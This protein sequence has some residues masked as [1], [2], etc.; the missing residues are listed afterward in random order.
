M[1]KKILYSRVLLIVITLIS[2]FTAYSQLP[3][4]NFSITA[5][6]QTCLNNGALGFTVSGTQPGASMNYA[7][8]LLPNTTTPVITTTSATV[9]GL[10]A[11]NYSVTATQSLNGQTSTNTQT[12]TINNLIVPLTY[13]LGFTKVKCGNDGT[14]TVTATSGYPATYEILTGP[15]TKAPQASN[16]FTGLPAGLYGVRVYDTCGEAVVISITVTQAVPGITIQPTLLEEL[17][18]AC[19]LITVTNPLIS[20]PNT[21]MF[22]PLTIQYTVFPPG[23]GAPI[24]LTATGMTEAVYNIP[25][26][27]NQ[28]YSYTI[29]ITDACGNI[30]T[31]TNNI[32][33]AA[34]NAIVIPQ[35][36]GC[37][38]NYF[39]ME[40]GFFVPPYTLN[41]T[42]FPVGFTPSALN[43][44]HPTFTED[45]I[46][47][48]GP[49]VGTYAPDG[50]YTVQVTD[51]CNRVVTVNF[52]LEDPPGGTAPLVLSDNAS[53]GNDGVVTIK[54][55]DV[56]VMTVIITDGP[57]AYG[58]YPKE[59]S[60]YINAAGVFIVDDLPPG[61]YTFV[62]TDECGNEHEVSQPIAQTTAGVTTL[63]IAQRP[64]CEPGYGS[65]KINNALPITNFIITAA[66]SAFA[67]TLPFDASFNIDDSTGIFS[68]NSLPAGNY[69]VVATNSCG[70]V[71]TESFAVLGYTQ[72]V[73]NYAVIPH[74]G[75]FDL[76][77]QHTSNGTYVANFYLQKY[78][79]VTAAW[80]HPQTGVPYTEGGQ[81]NT[82]N[83]IQLTNNTVNLSFA[84]T[85]QFRVI[86]TFFVY[87]NGST[88]NIRCVQ[89]L[90]TFTFGDGPTITDAYSFPCA[91]SLT[92]VAV[93]AEGVPPLTYDI[94]T[95]DGQPFVINNGQSNLFTGLESAIYNF[96]VT[97]VCGNIRNIFLDIDALDA[98]TIQAD[99]FCEGQDS[100]LF[101]QEFSFLEYKWY[102][103][104]APG[105]ILS[106]TGSL[107]FPDYE[108]ATDGGV[109]HVSI[110]TD[111]P[112]SCMNQEL[113]FSLLENTQPDAGDDIT[114]QFC[115]DGQSLDLRDFLDTGIVNTGSWQ[116]IDTTGLLT[117]ST[118]I[119]VG[120]A[121]GTYHF[122]Y[123]VTGLCN[124]SDDAMLTL[125][126]KNRPQAPQIANNVPLC[127]GSD[128][129]FTAAAV[130][131]A[132]YDWTGPNGF[133]SVEQAP[134]V[135]NIS[136][137]AAGTYSLTVTVNGCTSPA[138]SLEIV[139][140]PS[141]QAGD[142]AIVPL[143]NEGNVVSLTDY[144]SGTFDVGGTWEDIDAS[145][146]LNGNA[147]ATS[148]VAQGTYQF[149]YTVANVCNVTDDAI[150]SFQLKDIPQ[151]PTVSNVA[152]VCEGTDV[153]LSA[154]TVAN[155]VYQ[156]TGPQGFTSN[157][158]NP[159]IALAEITANGEYTVT[160]TVND[161]TS[162]VAVVPVT[163]NAFPQFD[164]QGN[165][166][167]CEGQVSEISVVPDNFNGNDVA[168]QWYFEGNLLP[169]TTANLPISQIGTY[170]VRVD[171]ATCITS[172]E[173]EVSVNENPFEL[174][175]ESG[176]VNYD[177]MLWVANIAEISGA[178]VTWTGPDNFTFTGPEA[179]ITN[180]KEGEYTATVTNSEGC[181]AIASITV[182][183]TSCIIPKGVSPNGDGLNDYFD[184]SNL[185]V[186]ELRI[187]NRYG[188]KVYEAQNYIKEWNGQSEKGT[189]PTGTY[190]YVITL[191]AGKQVTGWVYLQRE[192]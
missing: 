139:V 188:L 65:V 135:G 160:V 130:A 169:Q 29:R 107:N 86:K 111:N 77:I 176:C 89:V 119:T 120:L 185:D 114:T 92:E 166:V 50:N 170:E 158:Q 16:V 186:I 122:R 40:V 125:E 73:T 90:Y 180:K 21:E 96:R 105:T 59:V 32:V 38:N 60:G 3:A 46:G 9:P 82:L 132:T 78:N 17:L 91:N 88:A 79:S 51:A 175:L 146:A 102:K 25:F 97:D 141:P 23:G 117:N 134:V 68:M 93:V 172:R 163:I 14:I 31:R 159:L 191:S 35:T 181:T 126:V 71:I 140:N 192:E 20:P 173:I 13:T 113:S 151:A 99:G 6:N 70:L 145:G 147:F 57:A 28:Q 137:A 133:A 39:D 26:Y 129:Q 115:N 55:D 44:N 118:L 156:W 178:T 106:T 127:E 183:N 47:Y 100:K 54:F 154:T 36:E 95:K 30:F 167:L 15:V 34:F 168:Y 153:Q 42:A 24:V 164:I 64:G 149:R 48:G 8:Y 72:T 37:E 103:E 182:D 22:F 124:V 101:V 80:G 144:L 56:D 138:A 52:T 62:V 10:G 7:V 142:D 19:N 174:L 157:E 112:L 161:C 162:A 76:N 49:L 75:S 61:E 177:Y 33:N 53:C 109:Y 187:F 1:A 179:N 4:F 27:N 43:I 184:L 143:C 12:A 150:I 128:I 67:E 84:Y 104:G 2:S 18:P 155:A 136:P 5:T 148:G 69:T 131:G 45:K 74:C 85:G 108:S 121:E 152:P 11:G 41:F 165:T 189:L 171:N 190:Y 63:A 66:P 58:P 123:V 110:T 94:T 98:I 81:A 83:S 87:D 116:E